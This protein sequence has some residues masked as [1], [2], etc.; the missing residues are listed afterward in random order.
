LVTVVPATFCT[1]A[2]RDCLAS[3]SIHKPGKVNMDAVMITWSRQVF[4]SRTNTD[5][6]VRAVLLGEG[7]VVKG[8]TAVSSGDRDSVG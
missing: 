3:A 6:E 7:C 2:E 5:A 8:S 4:Q 1:E